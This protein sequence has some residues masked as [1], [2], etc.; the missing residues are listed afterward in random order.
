MGKGGAGGSGGGSSGAAGGTQSEPPQTPTPLI[1]KGS[2]DKEMNSL[3]RNNISP[4][5]TKNDI[6]EAF[7]RFVVREELI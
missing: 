3:S 5:L 2:P 7:E 6:I 4:D 1:D